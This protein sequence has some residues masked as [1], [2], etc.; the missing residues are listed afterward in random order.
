MEFKDYY[1]QLGVERSATRDEIK[2]AYRKLARKFHPDVSKEPD[3]EA[4]FKEVAEAYEALSDAE[5]RAAYDDVGKR[6][7]N[8]QE[9]SPPPGWDSGF[10]F[11]GRDFGAGPDLSHSDFFEA[12]FGRQAAGARGPRAAE[13]MAGG[14]HHAKVQ[15]D[16]QD[17]YRGGRRSISL[18]VPQID[19]Q[20][21]VTLQDRQLDVNIPKGIRDGQHLRLAGQGGPGRGEGPAGDLYLEIEF[22]PQPHFRV[23]GR[24]VY[25]DLPVAP[26]EAALGA[27]V[28][29][30]TPDGSVQLTVPAGSSAGRKLRLRGK[31]LPSVPPGD[32]YAVLSIALPPADTA[33]AQEAYRAMA[34]AF[35]DF[36]PRRS[37]EA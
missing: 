33:P 10:E 30:P 7:K 8:G 1:A 9:F 27:S 3:A 23:D 19:A 4:R 37:L 31:G 35:G 12:L 26:W 6:H 29:L 28:D 5:K 32:L 21:H 34:K 11:S 13:H 17:S 20:G 25:V 18:R 16:L 15:I 36:N 2:R 24:D 14:D 22:A